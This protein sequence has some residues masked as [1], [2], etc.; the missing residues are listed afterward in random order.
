MNIRNINTLAGVLTLPPDV[1]LCGT[2][3]VSWPHATIYLPSPRGGE[4]IYQVGKFGKT[5][6]GCIAPPR[7]SF[8]GEQAA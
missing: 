5:K 2:G 7:P 6:M 8:F 3:A 1:S 4:G